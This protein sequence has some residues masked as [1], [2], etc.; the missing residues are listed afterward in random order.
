MGIGKKSIYISK[1]V[2]S[3]VIFQLYTGNRIFYGT[4]YFVSAVRE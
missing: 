3:Q 1:Q 4:V 2:V